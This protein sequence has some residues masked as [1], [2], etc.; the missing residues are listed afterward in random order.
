MIWFLE[1][2]SSQ[3]DI[4]QVRV[5]RAATVKIFARIATIALKSRRCRY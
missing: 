3:R 1:G 5:M 4:I 2:Q